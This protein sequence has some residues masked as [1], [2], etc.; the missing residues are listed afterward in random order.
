MEDQIGIFTAGDGSILD[1]VARERLP[2]LPQIGDEFSWATE[3]GAQMS[4]IVTGRWMTA[5]RGAKETMGITVNVKSYFL[6]T[7]L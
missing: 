2:Y 3:G 1:Y 5:F 4:G 6:D 7:S